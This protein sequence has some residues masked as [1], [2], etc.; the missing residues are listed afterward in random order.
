MQFNSIIFFLFLIVF[1]GCW[2][3]FNKKPTHRWLLLIT[4][5]FIFYGWWDAR[6]ILLLIFS[7]LIDFSAALSMVKQPSKKKFWLTVSILANIG[8]LAI[9]KYLDFGIANTNYIL[10]YLILRQVYHKPI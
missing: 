1:F 10:G 8:T 5:S 9:F 7:G 4:A 2:A 3:L 6:F